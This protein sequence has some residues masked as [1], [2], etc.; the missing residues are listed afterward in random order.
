M[1]LGPHAGFII[2]AYVMTIAVVGLLIAWVI[3]DYVAQKR[4]LAD[5]DRRGITRRSAEPRPSGVKEPA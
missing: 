1:D 3:T 4:A 2:V 5:L